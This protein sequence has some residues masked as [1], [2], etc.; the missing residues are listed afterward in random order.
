MNAAE[1]SREKGAYRPK[2]NVSIQKV[3]QEQIPHVEM[4]HLVTSIGWA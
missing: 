4:L 1:L 3:I 2:T